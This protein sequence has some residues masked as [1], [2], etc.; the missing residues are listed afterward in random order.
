M[1]IIECEYFFNCQIYMLLKWL[2]FK[3][4]DLMISKIES[5]SSWSKY[6]SCVDA[7]LQEPLHVVN[8]HLQK[9]KFCC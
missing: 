9:F 6:S 7:I 2:Y 4:S 1:V 8:D 5:I 3:K